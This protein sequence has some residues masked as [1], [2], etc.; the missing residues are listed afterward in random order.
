VWRPGVSHLYLPTLGRLSW[1]CPKCIRSLSR[2]LWNILVQVSPTY[3]VTVYLHQTIRVYLDYICLC[4]DNKM[5][6]APEDILA[7]IRSVPSLRLHSHCPFSS[8]SHT[9]LT[10]TQITLAFKQFITGKVC[11]IHESEGSSASAATLQPPW[12]GSSSGLPPSLI[13]TT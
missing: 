9:F 5:E 7:P 8:P 3:L 11:N 6:K 12:A 4:F 1:D 2:C 13:S 10:S